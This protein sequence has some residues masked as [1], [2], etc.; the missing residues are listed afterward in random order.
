MEKEPLHYYKRNVPYTVGI[1]FFIRDTQGKALTEDDPY[2][3]VEESKLRDFKRANQHHLKN[4]LIIE[5]SEP[6]YD[7]ETPNA[8]DDEK[9][10]E[11]VKNVFTLKKVLKEITSVS[12]AVKLLDA[13]KEQN[14]PHKTIQL[15]EARLAEFEEDSP[16]AMRGIDNSNDESSRYG[17]TV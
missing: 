8:I 15:I 2:V 12:A 1:R 3:A 16:F 13:A 10:G 14:R 9:A 17:S 7:V 4:G 6:S 11:I 5:T